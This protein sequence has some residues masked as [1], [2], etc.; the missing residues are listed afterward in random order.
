[1]EE[2]LRKYLLKKLDWENITISNYDVDG[3]NCCVKYIV[4]GC[5]ETLNINIWD[6]VVFLN[7][8]KI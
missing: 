1:M 2:L 3:A 4:D 7:N 5:K 6:I 8:M